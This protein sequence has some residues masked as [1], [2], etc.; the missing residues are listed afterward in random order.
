MIFLQSPEAIVGIAIALVVG[1]TFHEFSHALTA[2]QLGDHRPRAMGRVS[3]NPMRHIDPMGAIFFAI[4]GFGWGK[5]V[6]VNVYALRPGPVG[7]AL[8][9]AAGPIANV[10][11]A[12]GL[13][14]IYRVLAIAGLDSG[15]VPNIIEYAVIFNLALALFNFLPVPPLDGY[16]L[17]LPFLPPR[18]QY[19]IQRNLQYGFLLL[20]VLVI[21]PN[22]PISWLFNL[23]FIGAELLTGSGLG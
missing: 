19:T 21:L 8:V 10:I 1:I 23:A 17:V 3:L 11:V 12:V 2:D 18:W 5:P 9:A 6:M 7:M 14:I 4:A 15:L 22:S 16:N 20:L 13:A